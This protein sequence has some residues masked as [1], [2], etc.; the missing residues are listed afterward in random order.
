LSIPKWAWL[1]GT[2]EEAKK[3]L[4]LTPVEVFDAGPIF[5]VAESPAWGLR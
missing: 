5:A 4:K 2:V 3:L 1:A